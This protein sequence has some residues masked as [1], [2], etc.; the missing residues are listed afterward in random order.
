VRSFLSFLFS[1]IVELNPV[2]DG[3]FRMTKEAILSSWA[4]EQLRHPQ[5]KEQNVSAA[6]I[7]ACIRQDRYSAGTQ[8][9][10]RRP[11]ACTCSRC[12]LIKVAKS[13]GGLLKR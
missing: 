13:S 1:P 12:L 8:L 10:G 5:Y 9:P 2:R 11:V 7:S 3:S 6:L 4:L